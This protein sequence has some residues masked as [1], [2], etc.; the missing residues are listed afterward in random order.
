MTH[1]QVTGWVIGGWMNRWGFIFLFTPVGAT[2]ETRSWRG[3]SPLRPQVNLVLIYACNYYVFGV[4]TFYSI[5]NES[6]PILR[7]IAGVPWIKMGLFS[8][9]NQYPF[10]NTLLF[11]FHLLNFFYCLIHKDN[12]MLHKK[13]LLFEFLKYSNM[14]FHTVL[15]FRKLNITCVN[16]R[17][18]IIR[19]I[20][21]EN[22]SARWK[23]KNGIHIDIIFWT[24]LQINSGFY[25][26]LKKRSHWPELS[27]HKISTESSI[28]RILV[29]GNE[30]WSVP[31][32][33][34]RKFFFSKKRKLFM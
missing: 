10:V 14:K 23:K 21:V 27:N 9:Q 15:N 22:L 5:L 13:K 4:C 11:K 28:G 16:F 2:G 19:N 30:K 8:I 26:S 25:L 17:T 1:R 7:K 33:H 34:I 12:N 6:L 20:S 32:Y 3:S 24:I 18:D 31:R 29:F